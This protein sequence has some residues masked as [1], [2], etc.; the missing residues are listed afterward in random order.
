[1]GNLNIVMDFSQTYFVDGSLWKSSVQFLTAAYGMKFIFKP[2]IIQY[3]WI[4]S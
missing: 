1:M 2:K 4:H 3:K